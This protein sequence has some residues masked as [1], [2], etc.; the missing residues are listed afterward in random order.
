[1]DL[2]VDQQG[3]AFVEGQLKAVGLLLLLLQGFGEALQLERA[4]LGNGGVIEHGCWGC[5][6]GESDRH[7]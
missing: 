4:Q 3:Q 5:V 7:W 6:D 2:A 1:V